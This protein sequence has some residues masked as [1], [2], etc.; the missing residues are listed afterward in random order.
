MKKFIL[1]SAIIFCCF[2]ICEAQPGQFDSSFGTNGIV[3]TDLGK[4]VNYDS[5]GRQV[6]LQADGSMYVI[7]QADKQ[8]LITKRLPNGFAD[9][10][11]GFGGFSVSVQMKDAHAVM[12]SDGKIVV[13]GS[14]EI[15]HRYDFDDT[16]N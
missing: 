6:L 1:L 15:A 2:K 9:L 13:A 3:T 7:F 16:S 11:Y 8:T 12:Q 4:S 5:Y 14:T 10:S